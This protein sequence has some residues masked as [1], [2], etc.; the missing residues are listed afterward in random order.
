MKRL[1]WIALV[2]VLVGGCGPLSSR[3]PRNVI[4]ISLD[5]LRADHLHCCGYPKETSPVLDGV[6]ASGV[7][8][9]RVV[10][11]SSWTLPT[12][13]TMLTGVTSRVHGLVS[14]HLQLSE[15]V[16]TLAERLS[17]AGFVTRGIWSGPYLHPAFGFGRGYGGADWE[18]VLTTTRYDT[19]SFR[20][21][22]R[23]VLDP[24]TPENSLS[25]RTVTSPLVVS[26]AVEFLEEKGDDPFFLFLHFFDIHYDYRPP[27]ELWRLFDPDYTGDLDDTGFMENDRITEGMDP[28]D[29]EHLLALYDGEIRFTDGHLGV[30]FSALERE[31]LL[32]DTLV[33][34]TSDHGDEFFEHG[35]KGHRR[36]VYEESVTVPLIVFGGGVR[37]KGVRVDDVV[38][39][40]DLVPTILDM[41]GLPLPPELMGKSLAP[42]LRGES[43]SAGGIGSSLLQRH[44]GRSLE[45]VRSKEWKVI[46]DHRADRD[47]TEAFDLNVDPE[48]QSPL[49]GDRAQALVEEALSWLETRGIRE[50]HVR[51]TLGAGD[52]SKTALPPEL[53]EQL[54]SLGYLK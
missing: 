31:G 2:M 11:E 46:I 12:H 30:L 6:A 41:V 7:L 5:S 32:D 25:H 37:A 52:P 20:Q 8:F 21:T 40:V 36:S 16:P 23:A 29:R 27:E 44:K 19:P 53:E 10:A 9:E 1:G 22:G 15:A 54:R 35:N 26:R 48:E 51:M 43:P 34:V 28:R 45:S 49:E 17:A 4:L 3:E 18:G 42:V 47:L 24:T 33:L 50:H 14:D 39:H 13:A 38:G